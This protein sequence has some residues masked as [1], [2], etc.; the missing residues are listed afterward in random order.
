MHSPAESSPGTAATGTGA[1]DAELL[2]AIA[3]LLHSSRSD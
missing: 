2:A 3:A 1:S